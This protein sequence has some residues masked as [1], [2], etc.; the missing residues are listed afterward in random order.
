VKMACL[1]RSLD[2]IILYS[3]DGPLASFDTML[4]NN[5][6]EHILSQWDNIQSDN[7]DDS[8]GLIIPD[9]RLIFSEERKSVRFC[10]LE[11]LHTIKQIS[12]KMEVHTFDTDRSQ[13][14]DIQSNENDVDADRSQLPH[15]Q[16]NEND[17]SRDPTIIEDRFE[18]SKENKLVRICTEELPTTKAMNENISS[19]N[20]K[21]ILSAL[22]KSEELIFK[23]NSD[24]EKSSRHK[25]SLGSTI[26]KRIA[27]ISGSKKNINNKENGKKID[28]KS[29]KKGK[30]RKNNEEKQI[31][32]Y[33]NTG[34]IAVVGPPASG[35]HTQGKKIAKK[36]G[37]IH[38]SASD[39]LRHAIDNKT[40]M[41][42]VMEEYV[43]ARKSA[44]DVIISKLM[45]D[46][47]K[48]PDCQTHGW[49]LSGF[50]NTIGQAEALQTEGMLI[51]HFVVLYTPYEVIKTRV[52][53][54]SYDPLTGSRYHVTYL[55]SCDPKVTRRLQRI[56]SSDMEVLDGLK[57][58]N[59][60]AKLL[61]ECY[62]DIFFEVDGTQEPKSVY[63]DI[64][65]NIFK[66]KI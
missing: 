7:T 51:E 23:I 17:D 38:I 59:K 13:L 56:C 20:F 50:P 16:S 25:Y 5:Q 63:S 57:E 1:N 37:A 65:K 43:H 32:I 2:D 33:S 42:L 11:E 48:E 53:G 15:I 62:S 30:K 10:N 28:K 22:K 19:K 9:D 6:W 3:I 66:P 54:R 55:P 52:E 64:S 27:E 41:G 40:A 24:E 36:I 39:V 14:H 4:T 31:I 35:K 46:R 12:E 26:L 44:P 21:I 18:V 58:F 47:L 8:Q 60:N 49:V 61:K 45:L 34:N 29:K